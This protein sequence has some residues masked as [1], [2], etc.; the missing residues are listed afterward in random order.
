[1]ARRLF[2]PENR[3]R[4]V[5]ALV[6]SQKKTAATSAAHD[7]AKKRLEAAEGKVKRLR[8]AIE[9]GIEPAALVE[10]TNAAQAQRSAARA[11]LNGTSTPDGITDAEVHAVLDALGDVGS[12]IGRGDPVKL[13]DL[14]A[15]LGLGMLY[16]AEGRTVE[17]TVRPSA[18]LV[19]VSEARHDLYAHALRQHAEL[20]LRV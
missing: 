11:E 13:E 19:H 7:V 5:A 15:G 18:G 14:F 3:D 1:M 20:D 8:A 2:A 6:A 17:V 4:T 9:A 16:N 12:V 10:A